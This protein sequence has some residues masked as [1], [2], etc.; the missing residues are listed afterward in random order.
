MRAIRRQMAMTKWRI[1]SLLVV[2]AV[3][4]GF[5]KAG[6]SAETAQKV[7]IAYASRSSSAMPQYMA[8]QKGFFKAEGLDG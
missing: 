6:F 1:L 2:F 4:G 3:A 8:L 7:R 5:A